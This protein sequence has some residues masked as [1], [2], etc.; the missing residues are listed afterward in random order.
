MIKKLDNFRWKPMNVTHLGC[1][2]GCL[3]YLDLDVTDAWL[4]GAIGHGFIL[5]IATVGL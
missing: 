3:N 2:K 1:I 5:N 4:F